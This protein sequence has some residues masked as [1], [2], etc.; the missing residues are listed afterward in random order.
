MKATLNVNVGDKVIFHNRWNGD[1]IT[2][3]VKITSTG[4]IRTANNGYFNPDGSAKS[5]DPWCTD[6]IKEFTLEDEERLKMKSIKQR[7]TKTNWNDVSDE[8]ILAIYE[9]LKGNNEL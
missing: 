5:S 3:V 6:Y 7:I 4:N 8:K 2:K 9:I 1:S